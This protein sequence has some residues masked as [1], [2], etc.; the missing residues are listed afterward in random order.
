MKYRIEAVTPCS[1]TH[2][3][4]SY[5]WAGVNDKYGPR[6]LFF[7]YS[8]SSSASRTFALAKVIAINGICLFKET[9]G[10]GKF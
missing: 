4:I 9:E 5:F 3:P 6:D 2:L 10:S 7:F 8:F 1:V